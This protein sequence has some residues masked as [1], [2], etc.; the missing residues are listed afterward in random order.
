M[1]VDKGQVM[2]QCHILE[3]K[4]IMPLNEVYI[5]PKQFVD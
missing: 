2:L 5:F 1:Q 3:S 4:T